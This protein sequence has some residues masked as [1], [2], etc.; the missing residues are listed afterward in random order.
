MWTIEP[1]AEPRRT[2]HRGKAIVAGATSPM[3]KQKMPAMYGGNFTDLDGHM[4]ELFY[5][6]G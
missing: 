4:W 6:E 3:A 1:T 2:R 5:M